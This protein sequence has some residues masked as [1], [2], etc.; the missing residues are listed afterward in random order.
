MPAR[1][2][3][4]RR[5]SAP[6][7]RARGRKA[8]ARRSPFNSSW[9][10]AKC[11]VTFPIEHNNNYAQ[12]SDTTCARFVVKWNDS[13]NDDM[14]TPQVAVLR[15]SRQWQALA[16]QFREY[17]VRGVKIE[18]KGHNAVG[19]DKEYRASHVWSDPDVY[20][21]PTE[22]GND[23]AYFWDINRF[24]QKPDY[25]EMSHNR[26]FTK[27]IGVEKF[28]RR[29]GLNHTHRTLAQIST[30]H[31]TSFQLNSRG[32]DNGHDMGRVTVTWFVIF[33]QPAF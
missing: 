3:F 18:Y 4:R 32:F 2:S 13:S 9:Y 23:G 7:R 28:H 10:H 26:S 30:P 29:R 27:Y 14:A 21:A 1:R 15:N 25:K 5:K 22:A 24:I 6:K 33:K 12:G 11:Q 16:A 31:C 8:R 17:T 19:G 20:V